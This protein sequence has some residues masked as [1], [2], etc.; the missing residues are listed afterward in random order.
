MAM[1]GSAAERS[2]ES[3]RH[4]E[5]P[6]A[7][8]PRTGVACRRERERGVPEAGSFASRLNFGPLSS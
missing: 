3:R 6:A 5:D 2:G 4:E 7:A 8:D 1:G